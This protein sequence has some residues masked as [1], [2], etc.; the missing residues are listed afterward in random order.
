MSYNC[1]N[2]NPRPPGPLDPAPRTCTCLVM[3]PSS[4]V[5]FE[6][7]PAK[8]ASE[9]FSVN[10][11]TGGPRKLHI[12]RL[13]DLLQLCLLRRQSDHARRIWSILVR[14]REVDFAM[15]WDLGLHIMQLPHPDLHA[16]PSVLDQSLA[17]L[18]ACRSISEQEVRFT[19]FA[20]GPVMSGF[21]RTLQCFYRFHP[22]CSPSTPHP[23]VS[24]CFFIRLPRSCWNTY[25]FWFPPVN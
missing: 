24:S 22:S 1:R 14:C 2:E 6:L 25:A 13:F 21:P 17:Y 15:L 9:R 11:T 5:I 4:S 10:S 7:L 19:D 8:K 23:Q 3:D 12:R 20:I 16:D 18:K